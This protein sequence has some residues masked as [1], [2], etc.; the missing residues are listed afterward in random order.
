MDKRMFSDL[1]ELIYAYGADH[2]VIWSEK[3][4]TSFDEMRRRAA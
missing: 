3:S 2:G 1:I 4:R